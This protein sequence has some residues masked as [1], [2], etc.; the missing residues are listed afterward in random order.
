MIKHLFCS[1]TYNFPITVFN[2]LTV[3]ISSCDSANA[4]TLPNRI[5]LMKNIPNNIQFVPVILSDALSA[6]FIYGNYSVV[7]PIFK[8]TVPSI[9][10]SYFHCCFK[11]ER[12]LFYL[13]EKLSKCLNQCSLSSSF[14]A[15]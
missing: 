14:C 3:K 11:P 1:V 10:K 12:R 4:R 7:Q 13:N 8:N 9:V 6:N 15:F 2:A 5:S